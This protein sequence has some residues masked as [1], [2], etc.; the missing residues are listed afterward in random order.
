MNTTIWLLRREFWENRAIWMIPAVLGGLMILAALF[1][2]IDLMTIPSQVPSRAVGGGFLLAVGVTFFIVMSI[3]STWY[4]LD[5]L[6]ADRK[7]RSVLFWKSMPISDTA[8]VMS[9]LGAALIVIPG[10]YFAAADLT[11][12]MMAFIV[13][14]RANSSLGGALW[15]VDL[16]LQLQ[17]LWI[18]VIVTTA[19]WFLPIAA[20]LLVV[21]AWAKR[22][23]ML[24]SILPPIALLLAERWFLGTHVI[25]GQIWERLAGYPLVAFHDDPGCCSWVTTVVGNDTIRT[26]TSIWGFLNVGGFSSSAE[27]WIG[28]AVGAALVISAIQLR[29]RR[30]EI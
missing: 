25:A 4:L 18:Y 5:C 28:A 22:A 3:Y 15:H 29:T 8:T 17:V 13:S 23:V 2:R 26:P 20:Y 1:G 14:V 21:S 7:D 9:K 11:T 12:L 10:V 27:T 6:Y 16:W 24:W 19:I 30:T